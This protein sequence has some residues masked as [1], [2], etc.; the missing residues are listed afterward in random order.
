MPVDT[1]HPDYEKNI[2]KWMRTK[3][4]LEGEDAVKEK[5][6]VY[7]PR[8]DGME[9]SEYK[10]YKQRAMFYNATDRTVTGLA[11]MVFRR[12][13]ITEFS[14]K[15][16]DILDTIG[17]CSETLDQ[18][19][20]EGLENVI[21]YG[22][23]GVY[24]DAPP[25]D[26]VTPDPKPYVTLYEAMDIVN[27][28]TEK[29][30]DEEVLRFVVLLEEAYVED[31]DQYSHKTEPRWRVLELKDSPDT[32]DSF[33]YTVSVYRKVTEGEGREQITRF[34]QVGETISPT[35]RGGKFFDRIPFVFIGPKGISPKVGKSPV[36]DLVAVNL[37]HYRT[38]AD[39]EHGRHFTALPTPWAVGF[40]PKQK[41]RIGAGVAWLA[42]DSR[43][44]VG[45]LEFTGQGL[46]H[47]AD[48]LQEKEKQM[49][50]LG[51]RL[52]EEQ[53]KG[54][55]AAE[56]VKL[57]QSGERSVLANIAGS[58]GEGFTA[59]VRWIGEWLGHGKADTYNIQLNEDFDTFGIDAPM[60]VAMMQAEAGGALSFD[61][62]FH[63]LKKGEMYPDGWTLD[64][65][66]EAIANRASS[67]RSQDP[68]KVV[69]D[70][71]E[72]DP[73]KPQ[74]KAGET[75]PADEAQEV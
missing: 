66:L 57:R 50:V 7:L 27:W 37:S 49:A 32:T 74:P 3:D 35:K 65:E 63:N 64:D 10:A 42:E 4:V 30:G 47:L 24:V 21:S 2:K 33:F 8:L 71:V 73:T 17:L 45:M 18:L 75:T 61:V 70:E 55:E 14:S 72:D 31:E 28:S 40:E 11:G 39:L 19:A 52:L 43:A 38:S 67:R 13:P 59:V 53:K 16:S 22:R 54:Q 51:A 23:V 46:K 60:L 62:M 48:A 58:V 20:K 56:T 29:I 26:E 41:L 1:L 9:P 5:G 15:D 34:E 25:V 12:P 69:D 68:G 36:E 44:K 6:E